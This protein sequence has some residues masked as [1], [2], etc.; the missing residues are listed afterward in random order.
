MQIEKETV[1]LDFSRKHIVPWTQ[2][3]QLWALNCKP[4][5]DA[6]TPMLCFAFETEDTRL[7]FQA[8]S[9]IVNKVY[10]DD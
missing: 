10:S 8:F 2:V 7:W 3:Q 4:V 6:V 1:Y 9:H 5:P